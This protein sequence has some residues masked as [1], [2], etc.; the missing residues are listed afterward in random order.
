MKIL[1]AALALIVAIPVQGTAQRLEDA[2]TYIRVSVIDP[3]TQARRE[4]TSGSGFLV[5]GR[6][7]IITA[8]H[9][10][11]H[12]E[13]EEPGPRSVMVSLRDRNANPVPAQ[14]VACEAGNIDLCLIKVP[15]ASVSAANIT[16]VFNPACR[17]LSSREAITAYGY[18]FGAANPVIAVPGE[19]TGDLATELKYPSNVQ[20]IPGMSGGPVVD[21]SGR[22]VAVNAAGATGMPTL[23]FLQPLLYGE[24]LIRRAG[25]QCSGGVTPPPVA[26]NERRHRIDRVQLSLNEAGPS[27]REYRETIQA[28]TGCR[29]VGINPNIRSSNGANGPVINVGPDGAAATVSYS[30]VSGPFF[31]RYRGWLDADLVIVQA[32]RP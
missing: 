15:D 14:I 13:R 10:V 11:M 8:R 23:T 26:C 25:I 4:L 27:V 17:H 19:V 32:P 18:P 12:R 9:V 1:L 7:H 28:D 5:D 30:L 2:V 16:T 22:A 20:I 21:A 31:D 29:I 24:A 6:G 3:I